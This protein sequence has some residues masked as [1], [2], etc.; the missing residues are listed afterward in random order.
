MKIYLMFTLRVLFFTLI[1]AG[2]IFLFQKNMQTFWIHE[3][4][5]AMVWFFFGWTLIG[6]LLTLYFLRLSKDNSVPIL[7]GSGLFRL[8]GSVGFVFVVLW[9]GTENILWFVVD[10]F[11]IYLLYLLFDIYTFITNLRPHSE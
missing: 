6:G 9:M 11:I 5:G 10:F 1:L 7:L 2:I 4:I 3:Q 8:L